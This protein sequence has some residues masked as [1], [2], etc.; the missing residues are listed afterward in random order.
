MFDQ[1]SWLSIGELVKAH[2]LKGEIK[3]NPSSD[4]P[5]RFIKPGD[6]WLQRGNTEPWKIK[7]ETGREV[8]GKSVYIVSFLG[9]NNRTDAESII[10]NKLLVPSNNRPQLANGEFH[11]CDLLG[12]EVRL[13]EKDQAIGKVVD[14]ISSA[15]DLL[16]I[17]LSTGK[18]VLIPFVTAIV[19]KIDI[20]HGWI[21]LTPPPGLLEL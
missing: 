4:F 9:I 18:A 8:P 2:G 10:G 13:K 17:K 12:L 6:R 21:L 15:N 3:V 1:Q 5:E 19:P 16:E 11:Y 7:L 20:E 14:L